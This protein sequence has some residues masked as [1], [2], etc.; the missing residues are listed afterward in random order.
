MAL[1]LE[2]VLKLLVVAAIERRVLGQVERFSLFTCEPVPVGLALEPASSKRIFLRVL[3]Y[4][5]QPCVP[6][7]L[8]TPSPDFQR[9]LNFTGQMQI[10]FP[11]YCFVTSIPVFWRGSQQKVGKEKKLKEIPTILVHHQ[12]PHTESAAPQTKI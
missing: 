5:V 2:E 9:V 6:L 1:Q 7:T 4:H 11:A 12:S 10:D 3:I 8:H